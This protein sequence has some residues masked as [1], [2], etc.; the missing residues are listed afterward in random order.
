VARAC[1]NDDVSLLFP[2][3]PSF[4]LALIAVTLL[5]AYVAF[6]ATGFGS[7]VLSVPLLA[8]FL[9]LTFLVP[10][11][12]ALDLVASTLTG[13]RRMR[14][15]RL[16]ELWRLLPFMVLG[17]ALGVTLLVNL[18]DRAMLFALGVFVGVYGTYNLLQRRTWRAIAPGWSVP[19]GFVGGVFSALFGTG[20][21]VYIVFLAGRIEDKA[22][23]RATIATVIAI[24]VVM[25]LTTFAVSGLLMQRGLLTLAALLVPVM[26]LGLWLGNHLHHRLAR[27]HLAQ[28]I[29]VLLIVN[30][31]TLLWRAAGMS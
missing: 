15:V 12:C 26:L 19:V 31:I 7:T 16:R 28:L 1:D 21:P 11:V 3:L 17:I 23:L 13:V 24:S 20:G 6:G 18:P 25:R 29:S 30:G 4:V 10:M 8:H 27:A 9:P 2:E 22:A 5:V 14:Q